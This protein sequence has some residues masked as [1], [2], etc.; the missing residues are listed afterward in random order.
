MIMNSCT[1]TLLSA[2]TPPF[3]TFII[4]TGGDGRTT[5]RAG[6]EEDLD[7]DGGI[8]ARVQDLPACDVLDGGHG[9]CCSCDWCCTRVDGRRARGDHP[10]TRLQETE[11]QNGHSGR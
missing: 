8:A 2:C 10:A 5:G 9:Y 11:V 3:S 7:L 6:L 4:G 1:S